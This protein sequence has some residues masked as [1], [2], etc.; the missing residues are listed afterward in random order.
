LNFLTIPVQLIAQQGPGFCFKTI[1]GLIIFHC[2]EAILELAFANI[3]AAIHNLEYEASLM[4][5]EDGVWEMA[6]YKYTRNKNIRIQQFTSDG[7]C[8]QKTRFTRQELRYLLDEFDL[9]EII[10]VPQDTEGVSQ[11]F[12]KFHREELLVYVL[13][14]ISSRKTHKDMADSNEFGGS[15]ARWGKGYRWLIMY[16]DE[17]YWHLIGP[18]AIDMWVPHFP[19]FA[20]AIWD[21]LQ[22]PKRRYDE[23]GNTYNVSW[24][25]EGSHSRDEFNIFGFMDCKVYQCSRL[26]SGPAYPHEN[27]PRRDYAYYLQRAFYDGHHHHHSIKIL[28]I[29]LPNG[30]TAAVYGPS[31][32]RNKDPAMLTASGLDEALFELQRDAFPGENPFCA[33]ADSIFRGAWACVRTRH[34]PLPTLGLPLTEEQDNENTCLKSARESIELGYG[35]AVQLFPHLAEKEYVKLG[36]D[37]NLTYAQVRVSHLLTNIVTCFRRGNTCTGRRMFALSPPT[38]GDY[39]HGVPNVDG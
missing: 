7:M 30:M 14:K 17:R 21:Y 13:S 10:K 18:D 27:S 31:S 33:Y 25:R 12:Y 34:E 3:Q 29:S 22:K 16:L 9:P 35:R 5:L 26:G 28:T 39:L 11:K 4:D 36:L 15:D 24:G 32:G 23:N 37:V 38:V 6:G 1:V 20:K 8:E 2:A 19:K